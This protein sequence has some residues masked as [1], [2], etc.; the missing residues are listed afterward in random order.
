[1]K[2]PLLFRAKNRQ[3]ISPVVEDRAEK[4][5]ADGLRLLGRFCGKMA[6]YIEAERLTRA[7]YEKQGTYLERL[8][9]QPSEQSPRQAKTK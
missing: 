8:D 3:A 2:L 1:M 4:L 9:S 5:L 7:G 6:D